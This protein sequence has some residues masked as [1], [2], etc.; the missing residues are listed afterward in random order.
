MLCCGTSS[1]LVG[2]CS[3]LF[4]ADEGAVWHGEERERRRSIALRQ[5]LIRGDHNDFPLWIEIPGPDIATHSKADGG[6]LLFV[7][8]KGNPLNHDLELLD[9]SGLHAWVQVDLEANQEDYILELYYDSA[10]APPV[11]TSAEVWRDYAAVYHMNVENDDSTLPDVTGNGNNAFLKEDAI[12]GEGPLSGALVFDKLQFATAMSSPSIEPTE[13][14]QLSAWVNARSWPLDVGTIIA[15]A[16]A[17]GSTAFDYLLRASDS[18]ATMGIYDGSASAGSSVNSIA[19]GE[20]DEWR[21]LV[22]RYDG[23]EMTLFLDAEPFD[24]LVLSDPIRSSDRPLVIGDFGAVAT[25]DTRRWNGLMD[26]IRISA[27]PRSD[28][29]IQTEFANQSLGADSIRV[30]ETERRP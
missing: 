7:D 26:E 24:R 23:A 22:G 11:S 13:S 9:E 17:P 12:A 30:G 2:G 27:L 21:Y 15:K 5:E 10:I 6:D 1:L 14:L 3:L 8:S 19:W 16:R 18:W 28:A 29:W 4:D 25:N 20:V